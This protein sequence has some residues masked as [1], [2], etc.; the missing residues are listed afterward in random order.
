MKKKWSL[1]KKLAIWIPV[2]LLVVIVGGSV[3]YVKD[4]YHSDATAV[5]FLTT[6]D[7][8]KVSEFEEGYFF[9]GSGTDHA[10]IFYPGAKVEYTAYAPLMMKIAEKGLDVFLVKMPCNLAIFG[11][12]K[13]EQIMQE[14]DYENW[15]LSGHSLGGA[16][17]ANFTAEHQEEVNGL[18]L[19]AA[20]PTKEISEKKVA[21]LSLYGSE[22]DVLNLDKLAEG[23]SL[24]SG[25]YLEICIEGANHAGFGNYGKQKGDGI[26]SMTNGLQQQRVANEIASWMSQN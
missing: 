26:A 20:Y 4:Y 2:V 19:M 13:A 5:T 7:V 14:Y 10:M 8:V 15:Y 9:D 21:V 3:W 17:A 6:T 22:D 24:I 18:I 12:D 23:K 1:K 16:M 25:S 11:Q